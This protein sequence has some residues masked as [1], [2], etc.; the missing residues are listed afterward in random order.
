MIRVR[1]MRENDVKSVVYGSRG[2]V[3]YSYGRGEGKLCLI[4][5]EITLRGEI[6]DVNYTRK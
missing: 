1:K 6:V 3:L 5:F 2:L 4:R